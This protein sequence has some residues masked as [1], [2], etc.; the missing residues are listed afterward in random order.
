MRKDIASLARETVKCSGVDG[1]SITELLIALTLI[2]IISSFAIASFYKSTRNLKLTGATRT[3]ATYL[4]KARI[5]SLRRHGG[6]TVNLDS[7]TTYT[8]N[9][10]FNGTGI[11]TARTIALPEGVTLSYKLPPATTSV[12]PSSTPTTIAYDW[13]GRAANTV[14]ITLADSAT[15][16][17]SDTMVEGAAGD[18]S[19]DTTV[20][21]PVTVPAPQ[22]NVPATSGIK[23]MHY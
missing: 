22:T 8:V 19:V 10:D 11:S 12:D 23:S 3:L 16:V 14:V 20:T 6:A 1:Y 13:R 17:G 2:G 5:D 21:G 7:A 15:N 4:E 9:L 18:I